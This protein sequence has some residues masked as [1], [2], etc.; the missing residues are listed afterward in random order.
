MTDH[1]E[2]ENSC[3]ISQSVGWIHLNQSVKD[4]SL[5]AKPHCCMSRN[6]WRFA[7]EKDRRALRSTSATATYPISQ[8][9]IYIHWDIYTTI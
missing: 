6:N 2:A 5:P 1:L 3:H 8:Y 7:F 4:A 9:D